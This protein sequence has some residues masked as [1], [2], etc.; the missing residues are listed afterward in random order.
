MKPRKSELSGVGNA[1]KSQR[2][3][4]NPCKWMIQSLDETAAKDPMVGNVCLVEM[5]V[6]G[7]LKFILG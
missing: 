7:V 6:N 3:R 5:T 2:P 1:R 4:S